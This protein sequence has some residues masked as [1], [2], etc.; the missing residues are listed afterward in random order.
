MLLKKWS[1]RV[2]PDCAIPKMSSKVVRQHPK[3][4]PFSELGKYAN[5]Q[6]HQKRVR[7]P[8]S[9]LRSLLT[10]FLNSQLQKSDYR[11]SFCLRCPLHPTAQLLELLQIH[12]Q[13]HCGLQSN[14][15]GERYSRNCTGEASVAHTFSKGFSALKMNP[16]N[17]SK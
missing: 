15:C 3:M 11:F 8:G 7:I 6:R 14:K 5:T 9:F 16:S 13:R 1:L 2:R 4:R 12:G 10:L 17:L